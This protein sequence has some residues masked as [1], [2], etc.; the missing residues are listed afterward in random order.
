MVIIKQR[1]YTEASLL[2]SLQDESQNFKNDNKALE[3]KISTL[4]F[5]SSNLKTSL[6]ASENERNSL[7]TVL[8]FIHTE[9]HS[10]QDISRN[11]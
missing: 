8:K 4:L 5:V 7:R 2:Q 1:L 9:N 3:D 11:D 10:I 6:E